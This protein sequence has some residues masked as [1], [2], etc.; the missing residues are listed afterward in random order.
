MMKKK[1][2]IFIKWAVYTIIVLLMY[3]LQTTPGLFSIFGVR[4]VLLVPLAVCIAVFEGSVAGAIVGGVLC[5]WLLDMASARLSG[6]NAL[7][8]LGCCFGVGLMVEYLMRGNLASVLL[9]CAAVV[10]LRS[11]ADYFFYYVIWNQDEGFTVLL[12]QVLPTMA[13]TLLMTVP[14]YY[15]VRFISRRL[16]IPQDM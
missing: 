9:L 1:S 12:R 7:I 8:L 11:M 6:F 5:G 13:Y 2:R 14:I 16:L 10:V 15:L 4:P 3:V